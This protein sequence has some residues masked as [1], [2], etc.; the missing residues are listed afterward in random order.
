VPPESLQFLERLVFSRK[1]TI[2]H[3]YGILS[4]SRIAKFGPAYT[5]GNPGVLATGTRHCCLC[6]AWGV[7]GPPADSAV[8]VCPKPCGQFAAARTHESRVV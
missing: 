7:D 4:K 1:V 8:L 6:P 3:A 2:R 5:Q